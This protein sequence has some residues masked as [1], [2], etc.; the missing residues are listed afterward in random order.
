MIIRKT[1]KAEIAHRVVNAYT[2]RC[3]GLHGHSYIFEIFLEG[4][5]DKTGMV[6]DFSEVKDRIGEYMDNYD[7]SLMIW[8]EDKELVDL[9][10]KLSDRVIFTSYNL[11][12][13]SMAK[14]IYK[15]IK[16]FIP[17]KSVRVHETATGYAEYSE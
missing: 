15:D 5:L 11:T 3:R 9:A 16:E 8:I 14:Q 7:H 4:E 6:M 13:E 17:V 2:E 12:A 1:F 10:S